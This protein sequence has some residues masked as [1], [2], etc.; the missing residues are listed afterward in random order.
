M[1]VQVSYQTLQ[2][3]WNEELR[4]SSRDLASAIDFRMYSA[5][6]HYQIV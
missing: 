3:V 1:Q 6:S 4:L 5:I 2:L